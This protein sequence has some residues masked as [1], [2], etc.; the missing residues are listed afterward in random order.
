MNI[1]FIGTVKSSLIALEELSK[2]L[3]IGNVFTIIDNSYNSD[4]TDLT[5]VCTQSKIKLHNIIGNIN[6][7]EYVDKLRDIKPDLIIII[8]F[9]QL[10]KKTILEIPKYGCI[11]FHPSLLP[12]NRGR[13]VIPWTILNDEKETG[14]TFFKIDEGMDSGNILYQSKIKLDKK[15]TAASFYD[16]VLNSL[17]EGTKEL[18]EKIKN[19]D[20]EGTKQDENKAT[21]CAIRT[22]EDGEINWN[23]SANLIEKLIRACG[24]PYFGAYT[25]HKGKKVKILTAE[26]IETDNWNAFPGQR[27][28]I[29]QGQGVKVKTGN[30][31]LLIKDVEY[32]GII[33]K[34][35]KIFKIAGK[36]FKKEF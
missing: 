24:K 2:Y 31:L 23:D 27:V 26:V 30:G 14:I 29:I 3:I 7:Q 11:G 17:K 35:D 25:Y 4:A 5:N 19:K 12:K 1:V 20:L 6:E 34:A 28:E 16:K 8:G 21:Y 15:E 10:I 22:K 9:S 36:R 18:I 32:E 13:A 33:T